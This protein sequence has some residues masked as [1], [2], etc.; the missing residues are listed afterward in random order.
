MKTQEQIKNDIFLTGEISNFDKDKLLF[1]VKNNMINKSI[2]MFKYTGLPETI[3]EFNFEDI[4]QRT[5]HCVVTEVNDKLYALSGSGGGKPN[6]YY[7]P[8]DYVVAN[9]YLNFSKTLVI[10]EDCILCRNTSYFRPTTDIAY[11]YAYLIVEGYISLKSDL[12][13]TRI[14][15]LLFASNEN[16]K[17]ALDGFLNDVEEGNLSTILNKDIEM[18]NE[19]KA[20]SYTSNAH[21]NTLSQVIETIQYCKASFLNEIGLNANYNMKRE[22]ING[23]EA[24]LNNDGLTPLIFDMYQCRLNQVDKINK[25]YNTNIKVELNDMW[26]K[27]LENASLSVKDV[28][29]VEEPE[30]AKEVEELKDVTITENE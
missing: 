10:D 12:F 18:F 3:P 9:P 27:N 17:T 26:L 19:T 7:Y 8:T 14:H 2:N 20:I 24:E 21:N 23:N 1:I 30:E 22:S 15:S 4:L 11:I 13:N 29:E 28:E 5:G 25:K 16:V 6:V